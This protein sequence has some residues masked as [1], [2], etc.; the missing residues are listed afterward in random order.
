MK[1][2][3]ILT[4]ETGSVR[5]EREPGAKEKERVKGSRLQSVD[6][7]EESVSQEPKIGKGVKGSRLQNLDLS[8][9][10]E[11]RAKER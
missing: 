10:N 3:G 4:P 9:K 6:L 2:E 7:S 8:V 5:R 11:P 1:G